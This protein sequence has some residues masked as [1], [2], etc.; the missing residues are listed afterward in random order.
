VI[1]PIPPANS[2]PYDVGAKL[3][4][5]L[6]V[7]AQALVAVPKNIGF[8]PGSAV[9]EDLSVYNDLC[10]EGTAYVRHASTYPAGMNFPA[11][12]T[13]ENNCSPFAWGTM[14]EL[15]FMR[16]APTGGVNFVP[17]MAQ[18]QDCNTQ[19]FIDSQTLLDTVCCY[20]QQY[21]AGAGVLIG[22]VTPLGPNGGCLIASLQVTIEA[23]GCGTC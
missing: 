2:L 12:D 15:G 8:L 11:P 20:T 14:W 23:I 1:A 10:C 5:C 3:L 18:W 21:A 6:T 13:G 9:A 16:C 19:Y 4:A 22:A 17:T 7:K